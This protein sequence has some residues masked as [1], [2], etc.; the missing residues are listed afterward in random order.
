MLHRELSDAG[1]QLEAQRNT[2]ERLE[3]ELAQA[4]EERADAVAA[5]VVLLGRF[6]A[7]NLLMRLSRSTH[8]ASESTDT[9]SPS[10]Y[11]ERAIPE[12]G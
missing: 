6:T 10:V 9:S 8:V 1:H 11:R 3:G 4:R 5:K 2:I 7:C 12:L